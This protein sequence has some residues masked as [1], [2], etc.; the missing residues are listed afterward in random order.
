MRIETT[1][2]RLVFCIPRTVASLVWRDTLSSC[3]KLVF[4]P[5]T[6]VPARKNK[7]QEALQGAPELQEYRVADGPARLLAQVGA[8]VVYSMFK[9]ESHVC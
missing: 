8:C 3:C 7:T 6:G 9:C 1:G 4:E 2:F 5:P